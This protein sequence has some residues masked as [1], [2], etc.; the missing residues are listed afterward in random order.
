VLIVSIA[1]KVVE[2][3]G[4]VRKPGVHGQIASLIKERLEEELSDGG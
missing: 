3:A 4:D 1:R 2:I